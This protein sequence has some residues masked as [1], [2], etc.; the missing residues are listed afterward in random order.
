VNALG[1][2]LQ[3]IALPDDDTAGFGSQDGGRGVPRQLPQQGFVSRRGSKHRIG[4][5]GWQWGGGWCGTRHPTARS[6]Q[7]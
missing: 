1:S 6:Y 4:K 5:L 2:I 7:R 3:L